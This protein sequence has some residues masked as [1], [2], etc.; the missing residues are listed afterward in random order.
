M[1]Q[2]MV[3]SLIS[4]GC[5]F[6]IFS[7]SACKTPGGGIHPA[8]VPK[9]KIFH[10]ASSKKVSKGGPPPHAPAHGYRA[11]HNYRYYPS[12]CVYFDLSRKVYFHLVK[13]TWQMSVSLPQALQLRLGNYVTIGMDT[14]KPYTKFK[15]HKRKYPPGQL[16]KKNKNKKWAKH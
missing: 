13:G 2:V 7:F 6:F 8:W 3:K 16:K 15:N 14:D 4:L 11:K 12:A 10:P 1:K 9:P 5:L